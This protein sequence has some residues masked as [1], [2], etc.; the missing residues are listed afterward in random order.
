FKGYVSDAE[1]RNLYHSARINIIPSL[2]EGFGLTLL[3]AMSASAPILINEIPVFNEI[4][5]DF[6]YKADVRN[7]QT[8]AEKISEIYNIKT[9]TN[10]LRVQYDSHLSNFS[11]EKCA[12]QTRNV[13]EECIK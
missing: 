11:W 13:Y 10:K 4:A 9:D 6:T 12:Q 3:E 8:F 5:G 1:L 7:P 2:Y